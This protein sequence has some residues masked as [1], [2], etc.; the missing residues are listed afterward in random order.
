MK[1]ISLV[2]VWLAL[3]WFADATFAATSSPNNP[4]TQAPPC[5]IGK[6]APA[7]TKSLAANTL[8]N[9]AIV[10]STNY[11]T[12]PCFRAVVDFLIAPETPGPQ[13][14]PYEDFYFDSI[15][16]EII[17]TQSKCTTYRQSTEI[18]LLQG[19][20]TWSQKDKGTLIGTWSGNK[21]H[22]KPPTNQSDFRAK[23]Y[24]PA[25]GQ[26][27]YRVA[28]TVTTGKGIVWGPNNQPNTTT[29]TEAN[30]VGLATP[31]QVCF[32]VEHAHSDNTQVVGCAD[33][34]R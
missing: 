18:Y 32:A 13:P 20:G 8:A 24:S 22:F 12:A 28:S 15:S 16:N 6:V 9:L 2:I 7:Y 14:H 31:R 34:T 10:A 19:N 23:K 17:D 21:C 30:A 33:P 27:H 4:G 29:A 3:H 26:S 1:T 5:N 25:S 11:Y